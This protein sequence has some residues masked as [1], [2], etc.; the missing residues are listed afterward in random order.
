MPGPYLPRKET[1]MKKK[2]H[3]TRTVTYREVVD[4]QADAPDVALLMVKQGAA[5]VAPRRILDS[6]TDYIVREA[7]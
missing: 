4:V 1:P 5:R 3:V 2:Y 7:S 6:T